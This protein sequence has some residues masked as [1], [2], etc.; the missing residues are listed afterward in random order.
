MAIC[1]SPVGLSAAP[2]A[3]E[4][5]VLATIKERFCNSF[6][7][8]ADLLPQAFTSYKVGTARLQG[9]TVFIPVDVTVTVV[10]P[11]CNCN[12]NNAQPKLYH[13]KFVV[14]FANQTGLPTAINLTQNGTDVQPAFFNQC[15]CNRAN[16][17]A[18]NDELLIT[19]TPAAAPAA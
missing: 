9:T 12:C 5:H 19:I 4:L 2:V 6:C 8:N 1:L 15:N 18:I 10:I 3:N 11:S 7:I 13:E 14:A 17:L 16:G